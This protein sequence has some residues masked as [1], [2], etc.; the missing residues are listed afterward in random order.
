MLANIYLHYVLD[1]WFKDVVKPHCMSKAYLCRYADD[2][3][4]AFQYEN[5]A[6]R[7]FKALGN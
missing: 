7:F 1:E 5:D 3:V 6:K 4:C 2:F